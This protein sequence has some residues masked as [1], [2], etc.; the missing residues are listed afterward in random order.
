MIMVYVLFAYTTNYLRKVRLW[1]IPYLR[2]LGFNCAQ[3][4]YGTGT[5]QTCVAGAVDDPAAAV[6][7]AAL[8]AALVLHVEL[9]PRRGGDGLRHLVVLPGTSRSD[10][11]L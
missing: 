3:Y 1:Y 10:H 2:I 8:R 6:V 9:R 7:P 5:R 11:L 4:A